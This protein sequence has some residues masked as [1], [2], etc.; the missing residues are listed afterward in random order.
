[1][2]KT[3]VINTTEEL[4]KPILEDMKLEL[5]DIE[6]TQEGANWFLRVYID[7]PTGVDIEECGKVSEKLSE[8]LDKKD[9]IEQAYFL[10]V[11]SPGAERP[12]KKESD[13]NSAVGKNVHI[14]T[15]EKIDGEKVFEGE[16]LSFDGETVAIERKVKTKKQ[17]IE[18][19]YE[20]VASARLAVVF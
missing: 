13:F 10:E 16:L 11:S 15:Y 20:K 7:S 3:D 12:L 14:T 17:R 9:P 1:M 4:V 19:P 5:V 2:A 18:I 8:K 6:F